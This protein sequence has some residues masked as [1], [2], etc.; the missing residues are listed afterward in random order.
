MDTKA[1][2]RQH[3][4]P[5][6]AAF[7]ISLF[8]LHPV[9]ADDTEIFFTAPSGPDKQPNLL[10][11]LDGS[12]SMDRYDCANG[13]SQ[14]NNCNDGTP[15]GTTKRIDRMVDALNE[16][17]TT[18]N[19]INVGVMR[20]SHSD[21]GGRIIYP[22][23]NINQQVRDDIR[24]Q[25]TQF[26]AN[27]GT[28]AV[29]AL[30]EAKRYFAGDPVG[31]GRNRGVTGNTRHS[32]VSHP[33]SYTGGTV[34][35]RAE[36]NDGNLNSWQCANETINGNPVYTSP[37]AHEC[38]QNHIVLLTDGVPSADNSAANAVTNL[39]GASCDAESQG[40]G[41][42]GKELAQYINTTDLQTRSG[43]QTITTHTIGFNLDIPWLADIAAAGGGG[44][45]TADSAADLSAALAGILSNVATE[46]TTFVAPGATIDQF[47]RLSHR[48]DV[49]LAMFQP[50]LRPGWKG[51]LK[52]YELKGS[53]P[54]LFDATNSPATNP[55]QGVF[56]DTASSF[57]S[58]GIE[59]GNETL[60][61]GAAS[62]MDP[63]SRNILTYIPG[64]KNLTANQ[65]RIAIGNTQITNWDLDA[66]N[67]A[68]R[69]NLIQWLQGYDVKDEDGDQDTTDSRNHMGD[70]LHSRPVLVNY[71]T[72]AN[73]DS[74][75]F[76]G[77]NE[78]F[79]HAID[80]DLGEE[81]YAF[82]PR[83]LLRNVN[84]FYK[85][86]I[87]SAGASR[88]YGLD[89]DLT[90][91]IIDNNRD[92]LVSGTDQAFIYAG[93]RRGG[94]NYYA[95]DISDKNNPK[96]KWEITG[97][98]GWATELGETWS[99]PVVANIKVGNTKK[100]VIIFGGGYDNSQDTK[101]TRQ[102]DSM[103]R[104][105]YI[106]DADTKEPVWIGT[107]NNTGAEVYAEVFDDMQ[108]SFPSNI[109]VVNTGSDNL[110]TQFYVGDT[111]GRIWRFDINNGE[112]GDDLVDGGIIADLAADNATADTRRFYHP[113]DLSL[114]RINGRKV[115]NIA[116]GSGYQAHPLDRIIEDR[117]FLL[118]YP[119]A[120]SDN[121]GLL[122][123]AVA[124][125]YRPITATDLYDTTDNKI[126][127]GTLQ[128][129][130]DA[131]Q[132]LASKSGWFITMERAGEK[133]LGQ[134]NTLDATIKFVSYVPGSGLQNCGP[135]IGNSFFWSVKL[136]D[137]SPVAEL[138]PDGEQPEKQYRFKEVP[139]GG[140]APPVQTLFV[141]HN[142]SITP[143]TVVGPTVMSEG[144]ASEVLKRW[145]W[146]E[147]PEL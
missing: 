68:E 120:A 57:W 56:L 55:A 118:R 67:A 38:Q 39:I 123:N 69:N 7:S 119:Y 111:G 34:F 128:E 16:V 99:K 10:L 95:L 53:P 31:Y 121:Y 117:F 78:G 124:Q 97:G 89:G 114:S 33:D 134:S 140:L 37:I 136:Q 52:K 61:G 113:P 4:K 14:Y 29:G 144:D 72:A 122:D 41:T 98:L 64:D 74:V 50:S 131:K 70:P 22:M 126:A 93:M 24:Q 49:Y 27:H 75:T 28:P 107:I 135:D 3:L 116:I 130:N 23:R 19:N 66:A 15:N 92:G 143:T 91:N 105:I 82:M 142:D 100:Q 146:A 85:N 46:D 20:F 77:T 44:Y 145:Y 103:G 127:E 35:R 62:R 137:G 26:N 59:D 12:G 133:I 125:T 81:L 106:I 58:G 13:A 54:Q 139:G 76:V 42:C 115:I 86:E 47:T 79:L 60:V 51:N 65:N 17:L 94:R 43:D 84:T 132:Q 11:V 108:Y 80:T 83:T 36:C 102:P 25:L 90:L 129:I 6:L 30:L 18:T 138:I 2:F 141:E 32:R 48:Q 96:H 109:Q 88:P 9:W 147:V 101:T 5:C 1:S 71:G 104:A 112:I 40:R 110:A 73:T 21:S 8:A 63:A 87:I 45:Y